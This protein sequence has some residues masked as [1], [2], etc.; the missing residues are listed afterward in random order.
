MLL[1]EEERKSPISKVDMFNNVEIFTYLGIKITPKLE[2]IVTKNY[3][4][5]F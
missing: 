2:D 3:N 5:I 4:S 1:N